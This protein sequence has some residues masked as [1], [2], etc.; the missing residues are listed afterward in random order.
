MVEALCRPDPAKLVAL[1][2]ADSFSNRGST[3]SR[4]PSPLQ[5][6]KPECHASAERRSQIRTR[7]ARGPDVEAGS[8]ASAA[9]VFPL[10]SVTRVF[11][12]DKNA[13]RDGRTRLEQNFD[14]WASEDQPDC[15]AHLHSMEFARETGVLAQS[16]EDKLCGNARA[17]PTDGMAFLTPS[18]KPVW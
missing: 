15:G 1:P 8:T 4:S 9:G 5:S 13:R 2:G 18:L 7:P 3:P 17:Q 11:L 16:W 6:T 12:A 10:K 14:D